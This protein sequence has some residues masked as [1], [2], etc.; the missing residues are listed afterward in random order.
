[1]ERDL[2]VLVDQRL[3]M[4]WPL[5]SEIQL[6]PGLHPEH[7]GQQILLLCSTQVRPHLGFCTQ[8]WCPQYEDGSDKTRSNE[9]KLQ[10]GKFR[11][12]TEE[13]QILPCEGDETLVQVA[14]EAVD[15]PSL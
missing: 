14:R 11:L 1:M 5:C 15:V 8:F 10:K 9:F 4:P 7:C 3:D 2:G 6:C 12:D 13:I